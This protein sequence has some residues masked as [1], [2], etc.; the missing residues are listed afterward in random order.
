MDTGLL[1]HGCRRLAAGELLRL[2][3]ADG[4]RMSVTRGVVWVT[5]AGSRRD[6]VVAGGESV[7]FAGGGLVVVEPLGGEA[8]VVLEDGIVATGAANQ[9]ARPRP[10][11]WQRAMDVAEWLFG[12]DAAESRQPLIEAVRHRTA[13]RG[14]PY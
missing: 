9:P 2:D 5:Q 12:C 6:R 7:A 10:S 14:G 11:L 13:G 4:R 1:E 8:A 3:H